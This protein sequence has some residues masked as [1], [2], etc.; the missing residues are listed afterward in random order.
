MKLVIS[1]L[2]AASLPFARAAGDAVDRIPYLRTGHGQAGGGLQVFEGVDC[3]T[4]CRD[5][6]GCLVGSSCLPLPDDGAWEK[7]DCKGS[8]G[9]DKHGERV[10]VV[11]CEGGAFSAAEGKS[12]QGGPGD[13]CVDLCKDRKGCVVDVDFCHGDKDCA[14]AVGTEKSHDIFC[15]SDSP[16]ADECTSEQEQYDYVKTQWCE[17]PILMASPPTTPDSVTLEEHRA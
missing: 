5:D 14:K 8:K 7:K 13:L 16:S 10:Q 11:W 2:A 6:T 3:A 17:G 15:N 12:Q 9:Y 4:G 1:L